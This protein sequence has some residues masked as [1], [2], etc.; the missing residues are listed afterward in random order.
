MAPSTPYLDTKYKD[1][2]DL[3]FVFRK[4][5]PGPASLPPGFDNGRREMTS[6]WPLHLCTHTYLVGLAEAIKKKKSTTCK[7]EIILYR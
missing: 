7:G 5:A 1:Y 4:N 2:S 6:L 3:S